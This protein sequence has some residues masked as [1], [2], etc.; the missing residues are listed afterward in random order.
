M[1]QLI[2]VVKD[3]DVNKIKHVKYFSLLLDESNDIVLPHVCILAHTR[4]GRPIRVWDIPYAYGPI[5]CPIRVWASH[6]SIRVW[7]VPYVYGISR[8]R[9]GQ[10]LMSNTVSVTVYTELKVRATCARQLG[11]RETE[12]N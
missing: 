6:M 12:G 5:L 3:T 8:T 7:D 11:D 9:M 10:Y 1:H 4:M 2:V